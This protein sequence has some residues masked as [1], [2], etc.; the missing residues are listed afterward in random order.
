MSEDDKATPDNPISAAVDK[1][2]NPVY[3]DLFQ[4]TLKEL[5][6]GV[7]GL[8]A[9]YMH[10]WRAK[11]ILAQSNLA[12]LEQALE[13]K[14]IEMS[15]NKKVSPDPAILIPTLDAASYTAHHK[16]I[17][18][19]FANLLASAV[20]AD[21]SEKVHPSFI[22]IIRQLTPEE[23]RLISKL[24]HKYNHAVLLISQRTPT[25]RKEYIKNII[26]DE[27]DSEEIGKYWLPLESLA[28]HRL[29][30]IEYG[31]KIRDSAY[32]PIIKNLESKLDSSKIVDDDYYDP[33][34]HGDSRM[35]YVKGIIETTLFGQMFISVCVN[36]GD[37]I[38]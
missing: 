36:E 13:P 30:I 17:R 20:N 16:D 5:G 2:L 18:D 28:R 25:G 27:M 19:M 9:Y 26:D 12:L 1:L 35:T 23:A 10:G 14:I 31:R 37:Q 34:V 38:E 3:I 22:D 11:G 6:Q 7:G 21:S 24:S 29:I 15:E 4:P 33:K 8:A 32:D